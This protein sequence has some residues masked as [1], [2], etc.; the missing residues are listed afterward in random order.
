VEYDGKPGKSI[1]AVGRVGS[2]FVWLGMVPNGDM[3]V[4]FDPAAH[5]DVTSWLDSL[6][7]KVKQNIPLTI[8]LFGKPVGHDYYGW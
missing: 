7:L 5:A 8:R 3:A 6:G 1:R 2:R 4:H